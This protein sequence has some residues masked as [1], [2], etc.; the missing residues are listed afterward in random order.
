MKALNAM[1]L[2][3]FLSLSVNSHADEPWFSQAELDQMLAPV[4][5]YPDTVLSHVLI[6]ATYPLEVIQAAR[7]SRANPGLSGEEAV[8]AVENMDW[9]PSVMALVAFPEL[10]NRLD[11]DLEWTHRLGDAFMVQEE[12]VVD[13]IQALRARAYA[14]G[15]LKTNEHV[16][17]VRETQYI[18]IEPA[19]TRVVYVPYYDPRVVYGHWWW[20]GYPPVYWSHPPRYRSS[21][22]FYWG[23]AYRVAPAFYFSSFHWSRRQVVVVHHHHHHHHNRHFRSGREVA[24]YSNSRHWQHNPHHRRG[25]SYH[26]GV[27]ERRFSQERSRSEAGS[28]RAAGRTAPVRAAQQRSNQRDWAAQRRENIEL[29]TTDR[30]QRSTAQRSTARR[31]STST[32]RLDNGG[33]TAQRS[34]E[35]AAAGRAER[36][37]QRSVAGASNTGRSRTGDTGQRQVTP[38]RNA[39]Q[40][41]ENLADRQQGSRIERAGR[42][43]GEAAGSTR[44]AAER[45][46]PARQREAT[47]TATPVPEQRQRQTVR[48]APERVQPSRQS[49][50][51]ESAPVRRADAPAVQAPAPRQQAPVRAAPQRQ[52]PAQAA[53]QRQAPVQAAPQRQAAP[54]QAPQRQAPVQSAPQRQAPP[55]R[56]APAPHSAPQRSA[57]PAQQRST[58]AAPS[59]SGSN[60]RRRRD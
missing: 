58:P 40:L 35:R 54:A 2:A 45:Q 20:T 14:Q 25:V 43:A 31:D 18:Y 16:R 57:P 49:P 5:L 1:L 10:L 53:P 8:A 19:R 42:Q 3:I 12:Q 13:T 28:L 48:P 23:P 44:P 11:E 26:Q 60:E 30:A 36:T 22:S 33:S 52:A 38:N 34:S 51:R 41:Q 56:S 47:G 39:R 27:S 4:A 6:A 29:G 15:N 50:A 9:D 55:P 17:V 7:W 24:R 59:R 21:V 32:A 37:E 46:V